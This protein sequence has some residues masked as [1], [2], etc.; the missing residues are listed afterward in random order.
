MAV[1]VA[2]ILGVVVL[3][4]ALGLFLHRRRPPP[5]VLLVTLDTTRADRLGCYG[6]ADARTPT[7]DALAAEGVLFERAYASCPL[8]LPSHATMLT[9]LHPP[10]HGL[11]IN[12]DGVLHASIPTLAELLADRGLRAGA[13]VAAY[14]LDSKFGLDR[15]FETYDDDLRGGSYSHERLHRFRPGFFVVE[16]ALRW[17]K[18]LGG[19]P[20]FCWVHLFDAHAPYSPHTDMFGDVFTARPY[21]GEIAYQDVQVARLLSFLDEQ[22][23]RE[24]TWIIVS[25]DHGEGL[26]DHGEKLH[27]NFVYDTTL[28]VPLLVNGPRVEPGTRVDAL[29]SL[30]DLMPTVLDLAG[31]RVPDGVTGGS[32]LPAVAG[33]AIA[34]R[35]CYGESDLPLRAHACAPLRCLIE[36]DWKYIRSPRP[37]LYDLIEDPGEASNVHALRPGI[38]SSMAQRLA[39]TEETMKHAAAATL[40][41]S[42]REQQALR[43]LGYAGGTGAT[44]APD[45]PMR[46]IKD[47]MPLLNLS[48]DALLLREAGRVDE[49]LELSH[50][51]VAGAPD[52]AE[53]LHELG[54]TLVAAGRLDEASAV[55][56]RVL[57][58]DPERISTLNKLGSLRF[59]QARTEEALGLWQT[60][61]ELDPTA[62]AFANMGIA[63]ARLDRGD[64]AAA[65]L[66]KALALEPDHANAHFN[67][68]LV[69]Y[70]AGRRDDGIAHW[71]EALRIDPHHQGAQQNLRAVR[72]PRDSG[73]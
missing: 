20:F 26:D 38:A 11:R 5:N 25:G 12:A 16:R 49:A 54:E 30:V 21:D 57:E 3:A 63:L 32:F 55:F 51:A 71:Q 18:G 36:G 39:Q 6:Y 61:A 28:C 10:E 15:G 45:L 24:N 8:T 13:F 19:E 1:V 23:L 17:L 50:R 70:K 29:V 48:G 53:L 34:P 40:H 4:G 22:G 37:E 72:P 35:V 52:D 47:M 31:C 68:G 64:N 41:L 67:L 59:Q 65:A 27:G 43:S 58:S 9:G 60:L 14:V 62:T 66:R 69:L 44:D 33:D 42:A 2:V 56:E 73:P 46:D 7:F